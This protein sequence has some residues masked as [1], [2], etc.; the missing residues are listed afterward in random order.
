MQKSINIINLPLTKLHCYE[1]N[2]REHTTKQIRQLANCIQ[3]FGFINPIII[4]SNNVIIAG[5]GRLQAASLLGLEKAPCIEAKH[6]NE[7]EVCAALNRCSKR[8]AF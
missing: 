8:N 1:N 3:Q 6:L 2:A 7:E 4:D 5:H